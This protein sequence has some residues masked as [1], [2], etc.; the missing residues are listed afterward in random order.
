M[1]QSVR[2]IGIDPG[3]RST[4]W[5]VIDSDGT[6]LVHVANGAIQSTATK[7]LAF[8]LVELMEGLEQVMTAHRPAESAVECTFV[9]K[10]AV[11]TLKLGQARAVALLVP[12]RAGLSVEEY[13]P[14]LVKKAVVGAG[15]ADKTQ[16]QTMV[17]ILL[18]GVPIAGSDAADALAIAICH[19][20]HGRHA[21]Q[22]KRGLN[23]V[24]ERQAAR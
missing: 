11:S 1:R 16:V 14:N 18:P 24:Q 21:R 4:G 6:R 22:G 9:N 2:I 13:A 7:D 20:H 3:L 8:R 19:A 23:V 17:G 12:A 5:G 10:N 15:H